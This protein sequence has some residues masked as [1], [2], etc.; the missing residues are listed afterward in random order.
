MTPGIASNIQHH[1]PHYIHHT[2]TSLQPFQPLQ[3]LQPPQQIPSDNS[4]TQPDTQPVPSSTTSSSHI[5]LPTRSTL[6]TCFPSTSGQNPG[7]T[8]R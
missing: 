5:S 3:P 4:H 6:Q 1:D 7:H 2:P 8:R